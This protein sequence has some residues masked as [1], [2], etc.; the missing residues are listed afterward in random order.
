VE[1][2]KAAHPDSKLILAGMKIPPSMGA[3]YFDQFEAI[4]PRLAE[5]HEMTLIPFLLDGVAGIQELNQADGIHPTAA[6]QRMVA[7]LVWQRLEPLL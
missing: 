2:V 3:D 5:R 6:G 1:K 7:E 4:Y